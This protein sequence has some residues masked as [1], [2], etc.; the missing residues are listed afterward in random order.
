MT[1]HASTANDVNVLAIACDNTWLHVY[2]DVSTL[3]QDDDIGV[4]NDAHG[5][6]EFFDRDGRRLAPVFTHA[7]TLMDLA[8]TGE[9]PDPE[10]LQG[11]MCAV[12]DHVRDYLDRHGDSAERQL[13]RFGLTPA[14]AVRQLPKIEGMKY[15]D[16]LAAFVAPTSANGDEHNGD[17]FHNMLHRTGWTHD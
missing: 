4:G 3:L 7:W 10:E 15:V 1:A 2:D 17:W 5:A 12:V 13:S 14:A 16:S 6:M 11:R 9:P 8:P